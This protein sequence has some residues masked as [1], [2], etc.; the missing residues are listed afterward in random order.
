MVILLAQNH[1]VM[2]PIPDLAVL[3]Q[4]RAQACAVAV[5][6]ASWALDRVNVWVAPFR[7]RQQHAPVMKLKHMW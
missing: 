1:V 2:A 5:P 7:E 4:Q 6:P 3:T